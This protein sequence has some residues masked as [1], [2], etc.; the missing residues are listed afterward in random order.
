MRM[1]EARAARVVRRA[2]LPFSQHVEDPRSR[3][4][5]AL[6]GILSIVVA[7][8]SC[9]DYS[10]RDIEGFSES[11]PDKMLRR[12]G[13]ARAIS[14]T[15]IYELLPRLRPDELR[16]VVWAQIRQD[17]D[18]KAIRNDLFPG[19]VL[20]F[21]GKGAGS[22]MGESTTPSCRNSVC[23][24]KGTACWDA[25][26]LRACLTSSSARPVLDQQFIL[27]K[28]NEVSTFPEIFGRLERQYP[29]LFRYVTHDAGL[30]SAANAKV[31]LNA[32]KH[33]MGAIKSNFA[34]LFPLANELLDSAPARAV[35]NEKAHGK[36]I[37]RELRKVRVP[38]GVEFPGATEFW[39][40]RQTDV[41]NAGKVVVE[42]RTFIVSIPVEE[43]T[44]DQ[45]LTLVRLHWGIENGANWTADMVLDEDSRTPCTAGEGVPVIGWL[46]VLAY[47]LLSVFRAHLPLRDGRPESWRQCARQ[48]RE[49]LLLYNHLAGEEAQLATIA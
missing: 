35:T 39:G 12:L 43:L 49:A 27:R 31:A 46:R 16:A 38:P 6:Q 32:G 9:Q 8:F 18:S 48:I 17:L 4:D 36:Q 2:H 37:R 23:D 5:F 13:L 10:L 7:G 22:G 45:R 21:D 33:Y 20:T 19:G 42:N 28:K 15:A 40:V 29:K 30:T 41:N 24:A 3:G 14:D 26:A 25:F 47:N 11:L 34:K 1:T 44:D